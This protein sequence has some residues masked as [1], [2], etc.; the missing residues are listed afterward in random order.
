MNNSNIN[1]N[2]VN[3]TINNTIVNKNIVIVNFEQIDSPD[4]GEIKALCE[5]LGYTVAHIL[6]FKPHNKK[7]LGK[8]QMEQIQAFV[9]ANDPYAVVY[10]GFLSGLKYKIMEKYIKR[11]ILSRVDIIINVFENRAHTVEGKLQVKLASLLH[12]RSKLVR[13]WSHLEKQRG[14][15]MFMGGPGETQLELDKRIISDKIESIKKQLNKVEQDRNTRSVSR[16]DP[17]I[18]LI[19]YSNAGKTTLFNKLT[20]STCEVSPKPFQTL[21]PFLRPATLPNSQKVIISDTVGFVTNLPPF[22]IKAF[23]ATLEQ[24]C[25]AKVLLCVHDITNPSNLDEI[26]KWL[27]ALKVDTKPIIYVLNKADLINEEVNLEGIK[28]SCKANTGFDELYSEIIKLI[29]DTVTL[30]LHIP[31][32]DQETLSWLMNN[33]LEIMSNY[34]E[35]GTIVKVKLSGLANKQFKKW[36]QS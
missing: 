20:Q 3:N 6:N 33:N 18:A 12:Q 9:E 15:S 11:K 17:I 29:D 16:T 2:N 32:S 30:D 1:D 13:A 14:G 31:Y 19:G 34:D 5:D 26:H 23:R 24:I 28:I 25:Q 8:G 22:L 10:N 36:K 35:E 7:F 27:K 4:V 21:D